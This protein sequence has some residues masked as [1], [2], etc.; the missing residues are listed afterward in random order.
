MNFNLEVSRPFR[1][2]FNV[3]RPCATW[4]YSN[5]RAISEPDGKLKK[6]SST[7]EE[8]AQQSAG[9]MNLLVQYI[10]HTGRGLSF[11]PAVESCEVV[12]ISAL[13]FQ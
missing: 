8:E 13:K 12:L 11:I 1:G 5:N 4:H 9:L 3:E 6:R 7:G 10:F 2:Q